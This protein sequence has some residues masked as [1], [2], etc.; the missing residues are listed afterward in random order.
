M[1]ILM[2]KITLKSIL[3]IQLSQVHI[4]V[5]LGSLNLAGLFSMV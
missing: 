1:Y 4:L 3:K 5:D 2:N